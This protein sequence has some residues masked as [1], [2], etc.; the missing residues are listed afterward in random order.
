MKKL[1][2]KLVL[3]A[4]PFL[5]VALVVVWVDPYNYFSYNPQQTEIKKR[6]AHKVNYALWKLIE[7]NRNPRPNILLGDSQ[8]GRLRS[9]DILKISGKEY[10]NFSYGGGIL[11]EMMN[12]FWM[13]AEST[14]L[15]NVYFGISFNHFNIHN[16]SVNRVDSAKQIIKNPLL[17]L[18]NRNVLSAT[19]KI[20]KDRLLEKSSQ[21]ELPP[22]SREQF[23]NYSLN[24]PTRRY[25]AN[26][27]YPKE[28]YGELRRISDYCHHN[29]INL[30]F[31]ILP[32]HTQLQTKIDEYGLSKEYEIY[33]KDLS[34]LALIYDF[35]KK[36]QWTDDKNNFEDPRHFKS[37]LARELIREIWGEKQLGFE[38]Q[39]KKS[40]HYPEVLNK[41]NFVF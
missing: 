11:P 16:N 12:T 14:K 8:M 40:V 6:I 24:V 17:Y 18:V 30:T 26:Y 37:G 23:W 3:F 10:Y 4:M 31:L 1:L 36:N 35:N 13:A 34:K 21:I 7:Y 28:W 22:M 38:S 33:L 29:A 41:L 20:I 15:E 27:K 32:T 9:E 19:I 2:L 39:Q 5:T 25:Y